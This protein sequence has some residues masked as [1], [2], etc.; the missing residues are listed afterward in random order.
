MPSPSPIYSTVPPT[1]TLEVVSRYLE[2]FNNRTKM[3]RVLSTTMTTLRRPHG[4]MKWR[5]S[6]TFSLVRQRAG[7]THSLMDSVTMFAHHSVRSTN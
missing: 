5:I 3:K 7:L 2:L 1:M 4:A 6:T